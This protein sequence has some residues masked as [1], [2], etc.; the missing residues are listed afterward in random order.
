[1][2]WVVS[3]CVA[4]SA[5]GVLA[6]QRIVTNHAD[7]HLK[8]LFPRAVAF[9]SLSGTP[10]HF[11][12][13]GADPISVPKPLPIGL[14]FWTTDLV[15]DERAYHGPIHLFVGM[16]MTG[17]LSGVVVDYNAEPYGNFSVDLPEFAAQFTGK[18]IRAPF[19]VGEDVQAVSR[20]SI[21]IT[22]ATRAIRDSSRAMAKRFLDPALL[23]AGPAG[24]NQQP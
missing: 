14:A 12:V 9:S 5:V 3:A 4:V 1:M 18:S 17:V 13:Y 24:P 7:G 21:S 16:D 2:N 8:R 6:E 11:K 19:R 22:S 10:L 20:A 15:P 23:K